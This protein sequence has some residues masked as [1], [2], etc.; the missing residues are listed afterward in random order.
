MQT[1]LHRFGLEEDTAKK[2]GS[3]VTYVYIYYSTLET[4]HRG[5]GNG[6]ICD[7]IV[8]IANYVVAT[9]ESVSFLSICLH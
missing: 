6:L 1:M 2:G 7:L 8:N 9:P 5:W 4:I 3:K